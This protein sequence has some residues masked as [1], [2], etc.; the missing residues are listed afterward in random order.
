MLYVYTGTDREKAKSAM[1]KEVERVAKKEKASI[2]RISDA[3]TIADLRAALQGGGMFGGKRVVVLEGVLA[4][5]DMNPILS[6]AF[7]LLSESADP[8]F[9]FEERLDVATRKRVEKYAKESERF[10]AGK[11]WEDRS[12]FL[13]G[14]ALKRED[15]KAL[16]VGYLREVE[17]G[18]APEM[19][20][21]ILFWAAKSMLL[22]ARERSA[23]QTRAA[24]L[25]GRLAELPHESRRK[26]MD[27]ELALEHFVLS[28]A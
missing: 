12:V 15:K 13:L 6:D 19:L 28:T 9:I 8:F 20:H 5:E 24:L 3:H 26:G 25:V 7:P 10:D 22:A 21:G 14:N 1:Q 11:K 16:W 2:V 17:K 27:M 23:E 4:N 18:S